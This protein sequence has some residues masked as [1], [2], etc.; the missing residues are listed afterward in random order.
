MRRAQSRSTGFYLV[1]ALA[2]LGLVLVTQLPIAAGPRGYVKGGAAPLELAG[3]ALLDRASAALSVFGDISRLRA[4]NEQL[5]GQ[6]T[7]LRRQVA[8]LQAASTE[9]AELRR[10]LAFQ[11]S[12]GHRLATAAV[13]GRAPDGLAFSLT[14]DRGSADGVAPGMVVVSGSG[15]AGVV[16]E[17][18]RHSAMVQTL[19]DAQ[20]RVNGYLAGSGMEGTVIGVGGGLSMQVI[21]LPGATAAPGEWVLTS[22][23]GGSFPRGIPIAQVA[24]FH[25]RDSATSES[26][27]LVAATDFARVATVMVVLDFTPSR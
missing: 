11:K 19:L 7:S 24:A 20:S 5:R 23:I 18:G 17:A 26:A 14:I 10:D 3:N 9:N 2:L 27:D 16:T 4:E 15:L 8:E 25:R 1:T 6:N 12:F 13:I 22:G 21:P